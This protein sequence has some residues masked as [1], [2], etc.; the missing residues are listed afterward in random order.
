MKS[1]NT[2]LNYLP[3]KQKPKQTE[4]RKGTTND[5]FYKKAVWVN[6]RKR[7]LAENPICV[8]CLPLKTT[9]ATVLDHLRP[10]RIWPELELDDTNLIPCC[11]P[12]HR[13]KSGFESNYYSKELWT[14]KMK[15]W[16]MKVEQEGTKNSS[17]PY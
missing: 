9:P 1:L 7:I 13:R 16:I 6:K 15:G 12:C 5:P 17:K 10:R 3:P 14:K 11:E 4:K 8:Y 2:R